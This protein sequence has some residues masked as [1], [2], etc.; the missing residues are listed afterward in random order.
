VSGGLAAGI[1]Q[2][3]D[4]DVDW[5]R[6]GIDM[7]VGAHGLGS[8]EGAAPPGSVASAIGGLAARAIDGLNPFDSAGMAT[9]VLGGGVAEAAGGP[10]GASNPGLEAATRATRWPGTHERSGGGQN[11]IPFCPPPEPLANHPT[12]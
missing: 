3:I 8:L 1:R 2:A 7:V 10:L 12:R 5:A 6:V 4:G 9:S 11:V